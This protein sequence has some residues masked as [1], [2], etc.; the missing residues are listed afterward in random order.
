M[1][2]TNGSSGARELYQLADLLSIVNLVGT[3]AFTRVILG[4]Y[5]FKMRIRFAGMINPLIPA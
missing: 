1:L 2:R 5:V 3:A 4:Y